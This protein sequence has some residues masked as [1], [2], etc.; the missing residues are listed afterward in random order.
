MSVVTIPHTIQ[1]PKES[2]EVIDAVAAIVAH[3]KAGKPIAEAAALLP[4][5]MVAVGDYDKIPE[6]LKSEYKDEV[7]GYTVHKVLGALV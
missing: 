2:K 3:F 4:A 1:V 6:E 5:V 7:A